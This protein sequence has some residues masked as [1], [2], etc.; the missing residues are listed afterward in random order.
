MSEN[1][2]DITVAYE[3]EDGRL[4]TREL[5]KEVLTRGSWTTIMFLYQDM[6]KKTQGYGP[7]KIR[8][9]RYQKR[10][11]RFQMQ[12]K[13]NISSAKQAAQIKDILESWLPDMENPPD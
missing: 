9:G 11:G 3:D 13:F 1:I 7:P 8:I 10:G 2:D 4:L 5:N 6:D 12:S